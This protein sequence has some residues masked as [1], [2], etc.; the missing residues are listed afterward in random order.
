[1]GGDLAKNLDA[2]RFEAFQMRGQKL[3][4]FGR[5]RYGALVGYCHSSFSD[6]F[7]GLLQYRR[8]GM[9]PHMLQRGVR[10]KMDPDPF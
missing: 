3:S 5:R 2:F 1:A 9:V 10:V 4:G 8:L 6:S 7:K